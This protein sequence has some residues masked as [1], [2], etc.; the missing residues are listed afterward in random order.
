MQK[1]N[2]RAMDEN[3]RLLKEIKQKIK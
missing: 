3:K 1:D 2:L